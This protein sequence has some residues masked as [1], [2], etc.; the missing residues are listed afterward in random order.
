MKSTSTVEVRDLRTQFIWANKAVLFHKDVSGNSFKVYCGLASYAN[1][2]TQQ[3]FP[4]IATLAEKLNIA[5]NTVISC[6]DDLEQ[7]L[8]IKIEKS[9]GEHNVYLL[10]EVVGDMPL[11][12]KSPAKTAE[13][14]N[15][16]VKAI[17][18]WAEE[19][20]GGKFVNY[21]RQINALGAMKKASYQPEDIKRCYELMEKTEY[22]RQRGFDFTN[23]AEEL[24]KKV[25]QIR[26]SHGIFEHL[27][28][29]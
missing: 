28:N 26:Q 7:A 9:E 2:V 20:K 17:L 12:L 8:F 3:A 24:P 29:R 22:W 21:G 13:G 4:S 5:K 19:R 14:E 11:P 25:A 16:W 18:I 15:N 1:N 10:L 27:T 23:V 6:L